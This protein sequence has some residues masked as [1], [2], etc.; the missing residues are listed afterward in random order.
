[1]SRTGVILMHWSDK[2]LG[3]PYHKY[4][5]AELVK[6][7]Y[8]RELDRELIYNFEIPNDLNGMSKTIEDHFYTFV[9]D[10]KYDQP[11]EWA[12]VLMNGTQ[13]L[14]HVGIA[15]K[16]KHAWYVI[17]AVQNQK[18]TVRNKIRGLEFTGLN[19]EGY[20]KWQQ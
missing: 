15:T 12:I 3:L 18:Q 8:K 13:M 19:I 14:S 17:H 7:I 1:M 4:N 16:I 9:E 5:C 11:F 20:Y 2:Y 6:Y 10:K